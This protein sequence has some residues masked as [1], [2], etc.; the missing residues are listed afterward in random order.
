MLSLPVIY[1]FTSAYFFVT[2]LIVFK[3]DSDL[4][5]REQYLS[6]LVLIVATIIWPITV[7]I[8]YQQ[9]MTSKNNL[10]VH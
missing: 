9:R 2:W 10:P 3:R 8:A 5:P 7:P 4:S 1:L 6:W